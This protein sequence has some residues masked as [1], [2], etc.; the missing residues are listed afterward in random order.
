MIYLLLFAL[1]WLAGCV[2][3]AWLYDWEIK[4]HWDIILVVGLLGLAGIPGIIKISRE[5]KPRRK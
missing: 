4:R 3:V 5:D 2:A 1:W